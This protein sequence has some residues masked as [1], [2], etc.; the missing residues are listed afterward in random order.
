M[1]TSHDIL[2]SF[3][4][5]AVGLLNGLAYVISNGVAESLQDWHERQWDITISVIFI[6]S[7]LA[8]LMLLIIPAMIAD[9]RRRAR[10]KEYGERYR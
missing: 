9:R 10:Q 5:L 6:L 8:G 4:L 2:I 1:R 3:F 7:G